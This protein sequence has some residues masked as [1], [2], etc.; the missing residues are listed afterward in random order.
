MNCNPLIL[1]GGLEC[2]ISRLQVRRTKGEEDGISLKAL[3]PRHSNQSTKPE[4]KAV[5]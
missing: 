3:L 5:I 1:S 4:F 2:I